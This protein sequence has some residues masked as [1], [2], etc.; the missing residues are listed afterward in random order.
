MTSRRSDGPVIVKRTVKRG[1]AHHGGSWK[2]AYADFVTAMMA[3]FLV[4][5]IVGMDD[6]TKDAIEGYFSNPAGYKHGYGAGTSPISAGTT[7]TQIQS[8]RFRLI[9]HN[10]E[11]RAFEQMAD[12]LRAKVDSVRG[13]LGAA[14]IE[15]Q[16]LDTGLRIELIDGGT[17]DLFFQRGSAELQSVGERALVLVAGEL[18]ALRNPIVVEGHTDATAYGTTVDYSNWEL[19]TDRANAARRTLE[20]AGVSRGRIVEVRGFADR[21]PRVPDAPTAGV[22]RRITIMLPFTTGAGD[23]ADKVVSSAGP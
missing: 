15:V 3:F 6:K 12:R 20:A 1:H 11:R 19:S 5:W 21:Q 9:V 13:A 2:V 23:P 16:V 10:A 14:K 4:M 22:N 7:P 18:I 8:S 17:T